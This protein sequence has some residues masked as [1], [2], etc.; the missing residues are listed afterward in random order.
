MFGGVFKPVS[1]S[2]TIII[3]PHFTLAALKCG[4]LWCTAKHLKNEK[5]FKI[6]AQQI[7]LAFYNVYCQAIGSEIGKDVNVTIHNILTCRSIFFKLTKQALR[8]QVSRHNTHSFIQSDL[9][10]G[11]GCFS[12]KGL[13]ASRGHVE[14]HGPLGWEKRKN[15]SQV[16]K[17]KQHFACLEVGRLCSIFSIRHTHR[18]GCP[19]VSLHPVRFPLLV[20]PPWETT[21]KVKISGHL[22]SRAENVQ[23]DLLSCFIFGAWYKRRCENSFQCSRSPLQHP[24]C[25]VQTDPGHTHRNRHTQEHTRYLA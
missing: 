12:S 9:Q 7:L 20:I 10:L 23:D 24:V 19:W 21:E 16:K 1:D 15:T 3:T 17:K 13:K 2:P 14:Q 4:Q 18:T 11:S 5:Y 6:K 22:S 25:D 8:R